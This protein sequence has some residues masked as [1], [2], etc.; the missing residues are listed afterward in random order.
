MTYLII[1]H[2]LIQYNTIIY[3]HIQLLY[4]LSCLFKVPLYIPYVS[5][6]IIFVHKDPKVFLF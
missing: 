3:K 5:S 6:M 4:T 2:A 1:T